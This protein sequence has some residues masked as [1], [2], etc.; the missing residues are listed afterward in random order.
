MRTYEVHFKDNTWKVIK[1]ASISFE[2]GTVQ[3]WAEDSLIIAYPTTCWF[4]V[5]EIKK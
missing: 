5:K 2:G 4:H 3:F 1:A